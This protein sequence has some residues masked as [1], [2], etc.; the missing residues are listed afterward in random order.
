MVGIKAKA[1]SL[2]VRWTLSWWILICTLL[3][4]ASATSLP[5]AICHFSSLLQQRLLRLILCLLTETECVT[6]GIFSSIETLDI[7]EKSSFG[8]LKSSS[9]SS[10]F[11]VW[12]SLGA[13]KRLSV[14]PSELS[15]LML[16]YCDFQPIARGRR[17]GVQPPPPTT[18]GSLDRGEN[19]II[20]KV[21]ARY[22]FCRLS[23][24]CSLTN[25][26][27]IIVHDCCAN[28]TGCRAGKTPPTP[29]S[30]VVC[31]KAN[32]NSTSIEL[33]IQ[34]LHKMAQ[35]SAQFFL[36]AADFSLCPTNPVG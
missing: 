1:L 12:M 2:R 22:M 14:C 13:V 29:I 7:C 24:Y 23:F 32:L 19:N 8:S 31:K 4:A 11:E 10:R 33:H 17:N 9:I 36:F 25:A 6:H 15:F 30:A 35:F 26:N 16:A 18:T 28:E 5:W 20:I 34:N 27:A 3:P 21:M